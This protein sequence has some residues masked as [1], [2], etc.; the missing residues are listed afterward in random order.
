MLVNFYAGPEWTAL[1]SGLI[2]AKPP[3]AFDLCYLTGDT[4]FSSPVTDMAVC[5]ADPRLAR[6]SSPRQVAGGPLAENILKCQLKP[7]NAADYAPVSFTSA[8]LARLQAAFASGVCDWNLPGVGQQ[9]AAS[10]LTFVDG[11]GGEPLPPAPISQSSP[12]H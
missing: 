12:E 6:H 2:Q 11:P 10:P 1:M 3:T 8:Q 7:L 9:P 5:D 4:T